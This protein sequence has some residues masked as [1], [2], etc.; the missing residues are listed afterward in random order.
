MPASPL[1]TGVSWGRIEIEGG[2]VFR[3]IKL[4]PGGA[5]EW[6]W[7][8]TGTS[9]ASGIQ[10]ADMDELIEHGARVL[11]F[12]LG[13]RSRLHVSPDA[14]EAASRM[15]IQ[16]RMLDTMEAVRVYNELRKTKK[17]GGLFHTTC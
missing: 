17:V 1:I 5:R 14:I 4:F 12:S 8:E 16:V 15:G 2:L 3:D 6:D 13:M 9:H 11:V 10:P 7:G